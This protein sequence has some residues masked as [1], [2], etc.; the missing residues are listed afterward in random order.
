MKNIKN[1]LSSF[2]G[3]FSETSPNS[4]M[5]FMSFF[6]FIFSLF[7]IHF[8]LKNNLSTNLTGN[9]VIITCILLAFAFFPKVVQKVIEKK[10]DVIQKKLKEKE[11]KS[12]EEKL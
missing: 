9:H 11:N 3:I 5:R 6:L 7:E 8:I 12:I 2:F 10:Y 4:L 1:S